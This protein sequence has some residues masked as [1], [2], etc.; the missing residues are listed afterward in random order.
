MSEAG[1]VSVFVILIVNA[2]DWIHGWVGAIVGCEW[3][4]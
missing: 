3:L 2:I 1:R 4:R